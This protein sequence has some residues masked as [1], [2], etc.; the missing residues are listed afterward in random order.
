MITL[1]QPLVPS[2]HPPDMSIGNDRSVSPTGMGDDS[3]LE[4]IIGQQFSTPNMTTSSGR[5]ISACGL[6]PIDINENE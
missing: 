2:S 3:R 1:E 6:S 5:K 4:C